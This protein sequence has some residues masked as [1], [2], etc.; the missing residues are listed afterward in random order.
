MTPPGGRSVPPMLA[1]TNPLT[2]VTHADPYPYYATLVAERPLYRDETLG[3]WVASSARAVAAVLADPHCRVRPLSEPVP[4]ALAKTQA[5]ALFGRLVRMT[6]GQGHETL[7]AA[8]RATLA[9]VDEVEASAVSSRWA[10]DLAAKAVAGVDGVDG[11]LFSLPVHVLG[12]LLG[13]TPRSLRTAAPAVAAYVAA[14]APGADNARLEGAHHGAAALL[15]LFGD[16]GSFTRDGLLARLH[17]EAAAVGLSANV[18]PANAIGF[19][20]QAYEATAGLLGNALVALGR[21]PARE[22]GVQRQPQALQA[23]VREVLILDAPVQ[24]TR[25]FLDTDRVVAGT[26]M[27]S[28]DAILL[29]L[30]AASRDTTSNGPLH[31]GLLPQGHGLAFGGGVHACP[32]QALSLTI[33]RAGIE[34]LLAA[35]L[36]TE[37]LLPAL[38]YRP[39]H[40]LRIPRFSR[41]SETR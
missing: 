20:T 17:R 30:A 18:V 35:G 36:D 16:E 41:E 3:L 19:L 10:S 37:T 11:F 9:S 27:A 21:R 8:V 24:N 34:H 40:N 7:K 14:F 39:S 25:R 29:V 32:G 2:A 31:T 4:A 1:P 12:T 28:G 5:G 22:Q 26:R 23:L 13:L 33:A 6:D 15:A 38:S